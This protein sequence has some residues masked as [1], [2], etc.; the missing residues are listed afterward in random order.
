MFQIDELIIAMENVYTTGD[1]TIV[2]DKPYPNASITSIY[3]F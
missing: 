2:W 1:N 3:D